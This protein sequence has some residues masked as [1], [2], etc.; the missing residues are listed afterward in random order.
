MHA[1]YQESYAR[2]AFAVMIEEALGAILAPA[3]RR[4]LVGEALDAAELDAIPDEPSALRVF[5]EG[6][7]FSALTRH[8]EVRDALELVSQIRATLEIALASVPEERPR[9][10]VRA[11][12]TMPLVPRTTVV[13]TNASLVV[14]L[15]GDMLGDAAVDVVPVSSHAE[16]RQR[17]QRMSGTPLL[18][19]IDR[20]HAAVDVTAC[21]LLREELDPRS[22]VVWWGASAAERTM[23]AAF[24]AGGPRVIPCESGVGL[25]DLGE[26]C[27]Q[28]IDEPS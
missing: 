5:L 25:A 21:A 3:R 1:R 13:V 15:L 24:L 14:F 4:E 18:V 23:A 19:V 27:R 10:D 22:T 11:R 28:L 9:S 26:L 20:K 16:L 2:N 12:I 8:L 17:L 6:A 7:L